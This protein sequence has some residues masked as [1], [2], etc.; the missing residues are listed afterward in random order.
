MANYIKRLKGYLGPLLILY[1]VLVTLFLAQTA[2]NDGTFGGVVSPHR[3]GQAKFLDVLVQEER[4]H[5][6]SVESIVQIN[7]IHTEKQK[8]RRSEVESSS[9]KNI[10][11][12]SLYRKQSR[13]LIGPRHQISKESDDKGTSNL[14]RNV[15]LDSF[16]K[17][18]P[19]RPTF[20][21]EVE[22]WDAPVKQLD[23]NL[24]NSSGKLLD[25]NASFHIGAARRAQSAVL[26][27]RKAKAKVEQKV[28]FPP[29]EVTYSLEHCD[30][31]FDV[32]DGSP[33]ICRRELVL[34]GSLNHAEPSGY[35]LPFKSL[36]DISIYS[37]FLDHRGPSKVI[38]FIALGP[39]GRDGKK[40]VFWCVFYRPVSTSPYDRSQN[41]AKKLKLVG[42]MTQM[43]YWTASAGH[44]AESQF[45][46]M[47]CDVPEE[48][49]EAFSPPYKGNIR[50]KIGSS[51]A[52]LSIDHEH[53]SIA[54]SVINNRPEFY[55]QTFSKRAYLSNMEKE[56][57]KLSNGE[58]KKN[59]NTG[60]SVENRVN[61]ILHNSHNIPSY[62]NFGAYARETVELN[63]DF[64]KKD[65]IVACV[66]PLQ[67]NL[68]VIQIVEYIELT[69]LLGT[70]HI[71][72]YTFRVFDD[73]KVVLRMY[74]SRGL[75]TVLPWNIPD[76]SSIWAKGRDAALNDCL[77]RTM[78]LFDYA[79][80]LDL[81]EFFVPR[82][83]P[84]MPSFLKYLHQA[85]NFNATKITDIV[86]SSSYF[87]PPT[88]AD[89]LTLSQV[90]GAGKEFGKFASLRSVRRS[91]YNQ[92]HT[93]RMIRTD[94]AFRVG[95][96]ERRKTTY[97][98]STRYASVHHYSY[99]PR[100]K[101]NDAAAPTRG[102]QNI[103]AGNNGH[104]QGGAVKVN[105]GQSTVADFC[106]HIKLDWIMW[107]YKSKL[108]E[109]TKQS[110]RQLNNH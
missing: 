30:S 60:L 103:T 29:S 47:S 31:V 72:F 8:Q 9:W 6:K 26:K 3:K 88:K 11:A 106:A 39:Q 101:G 108:I 83:T 53:P 96:G 68:G 49:L 75:I 61:V 100:V 98:I 65:K 84:D 99:C 24:T 32:L 59:N 42:T 46:I 94:A 104:G 90:S 15:P 18:R 27:L 33:N 91:Y 12:N 102:S 56:L 81:D 85:H 35:S 107:R 20:K 79:L 7:G 105:A 70:Q 82:I 36:G 58:V 5:L 51:E 16:E 87:P 64:S 95:S 14:H 25:L 52:P 44:G 110:I 93:L 77:Y 69:L 38:R 13:L 10:S 21:V 57:L 28:G 37:S 34:K 45:Y 76:P 22:D 109:R 50:V 23:S 86:F 19:H 74:E 40:S 80:F 78:F 41:S 73:I 2:W 55:N 92:Q 43:S 48:A 89:Y 17:P 54:L 71:V 66:A 62:Q 4:R 1:T 63:E 67:G 97:T